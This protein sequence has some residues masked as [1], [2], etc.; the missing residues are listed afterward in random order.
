LAVVFGCLIGCG[1]TELPADLVLL[2]GR[3][4]TMDED[5][6]EAGAIA[7]RGGRIVAVGTQEELQPLVGPDTELIELGGAL[8]VPGLIE[9]HGHFLSLGISRMQLD[10]RTAHSWDEIVEIVA[11]AASEAPSGQWIIG[12]GWHQEKWDRAPDP[13]RGGLPIH[14]SLSRVSPENPVLLIHA[15]GHAAMIN[16]STMELMGIDDTTPDPQGGEI[17]RDSSGLLTGALLDTAADWVRD[18]ATATLDNVTLR[19]AVE[20]ATAEG[21]PISTCTVSL[22]VC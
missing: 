13:S 16:R 19:R 11:T 22:A 20:L 7:A 6:P 9:A 12:Q 4:V 3:I 10:L 8:A 15:S 14:D 21:S 18:A 5:R 2:G 17:L 1:G